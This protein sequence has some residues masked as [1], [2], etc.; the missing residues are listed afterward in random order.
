MQVLRLAK[1]RLAEDFF[2]LRGCEN[3]SL[4]PGNT[5]NSRNFG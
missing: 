1:I 2:G 3:G 4:K 5:Q